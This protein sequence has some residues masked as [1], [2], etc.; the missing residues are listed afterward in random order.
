MDSEA[1]GGVTAL[2]MILG[3]QLQDLREKAGL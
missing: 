3:R 1:A 2:R